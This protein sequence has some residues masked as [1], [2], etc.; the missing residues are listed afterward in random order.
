MAKRSK[1]ASF[2]NLK[3]KEQKTKKKQN[4][5]TNK[6]TKRKKQQQQ[7]RLF[8]H[9]KI[10]CARKPRIKKI[11]KMRWFWIGQNRPLR[12]GYAYKG[13]VRHQVHD[14]GKN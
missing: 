14:I 11:L 1:I 5:K 12:K 7:Q 8:N 13:N 9:I 3:I 4:K 2:I 10:I 6:Q